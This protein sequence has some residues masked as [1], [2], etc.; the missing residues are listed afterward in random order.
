MAVRLSDLIDLLETGAP[1]DLKESWDNTGLAI[2]DPAAL[3]E[4]VLIGLDVT[5]DLIAEA[6]TMGADLIL[7]HHPLLFRRP[8]SIT[9]IDPQGQKLLALIKGDLNV[10]S[11]HT[12]LDKA[13]G[14]LNDLIM[15]RLGF[16][17]F[18]SLEAGLDEGIGRIAEIEA[19]SLMDLVS[20]V[21]T[22]LAVKDIRYCGRPGQTIRRVAVIN[23]GGADFI[24]L[25]KS[26]GADCIITGDTKYHEVLDAVE[27]DLS[28]IDPG[29]FATEWPI[30]KLAM[31]ELQQ[32]ISQQLGHVEFI[33]SQ[34]T[35]D[36]YHFYHNL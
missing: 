6:Q 32:S 11:A 4:K 33:Y 21:S 3:I 12:N 23:G 19:T 2:G 16:L 29:H 7:T 28:I 31:A 35:A 13:K 10:Y 27:A 17:D 8:G 30:F 18:K 1:L 26:A 36:P 25:A 22:K 20:L 15:E 9:S 14:G 24:G 34:S 5:K